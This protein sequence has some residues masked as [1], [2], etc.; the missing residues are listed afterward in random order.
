METE[1][2]NSSI[3]RCDP[4]KWQRSVFIY[5]LQFMIQ[6]YMQLKQI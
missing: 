4:Q 3:Q 5:W 1:P 6:P 2:Q